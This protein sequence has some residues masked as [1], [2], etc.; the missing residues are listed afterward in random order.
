MQPPV[1]VVS[2]LALALTLAACGEDEAAGSTDAT[3]TDTGPSDTDPGDTSAPQD[4]ATTAPGDTDPATDASDTSDPETTTD[5]DPDTTA[6]APTDADAACAPAVC[7]ALAEERAA[8]ALEA[9]ASDQARLDAF[10]R[11]VPKGGDL[12][13]HLSG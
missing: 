8:L 6:D 2:L 3:T 11:D 4:T 1:R 13:H 10:L 5:V 7:A 9:A 12:H